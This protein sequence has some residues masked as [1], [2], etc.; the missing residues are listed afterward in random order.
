M[1]VFQLSMQQLW[2]LENCRKD[3]HRCKADLSH[4]YFANKTFHQVEN[5]YFIHRDTWLEHLSI[6]MIKRI[7]ALINKA[8]YTEAAA[9]L[10][11]CYCKKVFWKYA[12]NLLENTHTKCDFNI[13]AKQITLL[14]ITLQH[15]YSPVHLLHNFRTPFSKITSHWLLLQRR[16]Y[17]PAKHILQDFLHK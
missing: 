1:I 13:F 10:H 2:Q 14:E 15:W 17:N 9:V 8:W 5:W 7:M 6:A 12:A 4:C 16:I 3:F 11:S